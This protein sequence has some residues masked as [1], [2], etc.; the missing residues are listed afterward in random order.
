MLLPLSLQEKFVT[1]IEQ[2]EQYKN[3][4]EGTI[5]NMQ[6][7]LGSRMDYWFS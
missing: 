7:L 5:A 6:T 2:I 1:R 4:L 3:G